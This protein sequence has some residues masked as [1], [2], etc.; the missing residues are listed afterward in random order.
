MLLP[1][2]II[3]LLVSNND[4]LWTTLG[5]TGNRVRVFLPYRE[6]LAPNRRAGPRFPSYSSQRNFL[7]RIGA[8]LTDCS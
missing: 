3:M 6:H 5:D 4:K 7:V 1:S 2:N 8:A